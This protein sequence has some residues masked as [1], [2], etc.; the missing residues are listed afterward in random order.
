MHG[1]QPTQTQ[2]ARIVAAARAYAE[3]H[4][5]DGLGAAAV[6]GAGLLREDGTRSWMVRIERG[7]WTLMFI[8]VHVALD[9]TLDAWQYHV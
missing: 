8:K 1:S 6:I 2:E 4:T 9:G 3:A 7:A 5:E